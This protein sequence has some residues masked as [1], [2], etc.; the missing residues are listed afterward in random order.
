MNKAPDVSSIPP[1]FLRVRVAKLARAADCSEA[2]VRRYLQGAPVG[3]ASA[4]R[5]EEAIGH[6]RL[7]DRGT[8]A[9]NR[10][11]RSARNAPPRPSARAPRRATGGGSEM[12]ELDLLEEG[13]D[14]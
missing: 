12:G 10:G 6:K 9:A 1:E 5:I 13:N 3:A 8:V 14:R 4:L 2:Q 11:K 7:A